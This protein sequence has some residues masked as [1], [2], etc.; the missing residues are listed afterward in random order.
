LIQEQGQEP[1]PE[2]RHAFAAMVK[3]DNQ[4]S[5]DVIAKAGIKLE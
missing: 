2:S 5:R 4:A 3:A 1:R